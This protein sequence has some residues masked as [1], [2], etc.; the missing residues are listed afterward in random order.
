MLH[1]RAVQGDQ[2]PHI[3]VGQPFD[4]HDAVTAVTKA[5]SLKSPAATKV[6]ADRPS[7]CGFHMSQLG[8]VSLFSLENLVGVVGVNS[9]D[10]SCW[11]F[12]AEL[13]NEWT[14]SDCLLLSD[15]FVELAIV[16]DGGELIPFLRTATSD[17]KGLATGVDV[18][19]IAE[20]DSHSS[21]FLLGAELCLDVFEHLEREH[22]N[23]FA[24]SDGCDYAYEPFENEKSK[25]DR[26]NVEEEIDVGK[27]T[28]AGYGGFAFFFCCPF[29]EEKR[30]RGESC[31]HECYVAVDEKSEGDPGF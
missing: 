14:R 19:F 26:S 2:Q 30:S 25:N 7:C 15:Q 12:L 29:H 1:G 16:G 28:K 4:Q 23:C 6:R 20:A 11:R 9:A 22:R 10:Y 24:V 17:A 27:A 13:V 18:N 31:V 5:M 3:N 21:L 8:P